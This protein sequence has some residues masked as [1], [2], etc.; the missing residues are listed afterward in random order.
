MN[1]NKG[2]VIHK[3]K[4]KSYRNENVQYLNCRIEELKNLER[5]EIRNKRS[6]KKF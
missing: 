2:K 3:V 5:K 6:N 4:T 1:E